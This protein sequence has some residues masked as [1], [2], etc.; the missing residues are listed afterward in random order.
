MNKSFCNSFPVENTTN[1]IFEDI[2]LVVMNALAQYSVMEL[3]EILGTNIKLANEALT[4]ACE[5]PIPQAQRYVAHNLFSG[6]AFK[7]LKFS[8]LSEKDITYAQ[9]HLRIASAVYGLIKPNDLIKPY[10]LDFNNEIT[11]NG[12]FVKL[13]NFWK[14]ILTTNIISETKNDDGVLVNI[15]SNETLSTFNIK[16]L[17]QEVKFVNISFV[18]D[19]S[20][21]KLK[22]VSPVVAKKARGSMARFF[23]QN[24]CT[25]VNDLKMF[26]ELNMNYYE[27]LSDENNFVFM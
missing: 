18:K 9:E 12:D 27:D 10:R 2:G 8:D 1:P 19:F 14:D 5:F 3:T 7:Q 4:L 11:I 13:Q 16:R 6:V 23:I 20:N 24:R 25:S 22:S 15:S 17:K 26:N 21:G